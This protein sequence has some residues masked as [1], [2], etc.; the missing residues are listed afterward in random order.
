MQECG[1]LVPVEGGAEEGW[2]EVLRRPTE[3]LGEGGERRGRSEKR[4]REG[5]D[6]EDVRG[7][8]AWFEGEQ[9]REIKRVAGMGPNADAAAVGVGGGVVQAEDFLSSLKKR[10]YK[11]G[12]D[13]RLQGT[14][15]GRQAEERERG[16]VIEGGP[17]QRLEEWSAA[18]KAQSAMETR[19][20]EGVAT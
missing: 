18:V 11:G 3:A 10:H 13:S 6:E 16:V 19:E 17:V 5:R 14:V 9:H 1:V 8:T 7:F 15:L 2:E 12:D 4:K 20:M